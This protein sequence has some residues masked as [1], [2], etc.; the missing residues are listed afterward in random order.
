MRIVR[1]I[2]ADSERWDAFVRTSKNGTFLFLRG[3]MDY[4][5]DR[6]RDHSLMILDDKDR[7]LALLPGNEEGEVYWSHRGLS[8][9]GLVLSLDVTAETVLHIMES[10]LIYLKG[11]GFKTCY[12]RQVP[13]CYHLYPA[14]EDDYALWRNGATLDACNMSAVIDLQSRIVPKVERRRRRGW[15]KAGDLRYEVTEIQNLERCWH[16]VEDNL[17]ERYNARPAHTLDEIKLL[18]ARFPANI[19]CFVAERDGEIEAC[20]ILYF[21]RQAVHA[22]YTHATAQGK[23]D[24]AQDLLYRAV[25]DYCREEGCRYFDFGT[26]NEDGGRVLNE[27]L[28]AQ[29]EGFAARGMVYRIFKINLI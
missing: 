2:P 3:Y 19:R 22:Q 18:K 12:Y 6:F 23:A 5:S 13:S 21:T 29:K 9:G 24:G 4:H 16:I 15:Q 17:R 26:S 1:Y 27:T 10:L 7:L 28:I 11:V 25:I 14:Q 20:S 8:Y